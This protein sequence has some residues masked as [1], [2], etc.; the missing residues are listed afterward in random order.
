MKGGKTNTIFFPSAGF[1]LQSVT[2]HTI[3]FTCDKIAS[4]FF[5]Q[6]I[7]SNYVIVN[8]STYIINVYGQYLEHFSSVRIAPSSHCSHSCYVQF[9]GQ[10]VCICSDKPTIEGKKNERNPLPYT[11]FDGND[12]TSRQCSGK[13]NFLWGQFP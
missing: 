4:S 5:Y 3:I 6:M 12:R 11:A 8:L 1:R 13:Q 7:V 9:G 10:S 2:S